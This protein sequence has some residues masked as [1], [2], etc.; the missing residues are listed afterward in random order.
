MEDMLDQGMLSVFLMA[1]IAPL[2][3]EIVFRGIIL[4]M[5]LKKLPAARAIVVS[6]IIFSCAHMD[7]IQ[8]LPAFGSGILLGWLYWETQNLWLCIGF[9]SAHNLLSYIVYHGYLPVHLTGFTR[10]TVDKIQFQPVWLDVLGVVLL[11]A[12]I[13]AVRAAVKP[14]AS[15]DDL[16]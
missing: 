5:F 14:N 2:A 3:E 9:H 8:M 1:V 16:S 10:S 12:G 4:K 13:A 7:P 6:A 11:V 15:A